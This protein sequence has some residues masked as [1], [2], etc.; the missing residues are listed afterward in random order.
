VKPTEELLERIAETLK[1]LADPTR[2][3]LLHTLE[4]GE[5]RVTDLLAVVGTTQANVSKHLAVLRQ[6]GLVATRRDGM[7]VLYRV[8][9][10]MVFAICRTICDGLERQ[11]EAEQ[12][13]FD[14]ARRLVGAR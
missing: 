9:D 1:A 13:T 2:L 7:N 14:E 5:L 12:R 4:D 3:R 11:L 6:A 8:H 10:P